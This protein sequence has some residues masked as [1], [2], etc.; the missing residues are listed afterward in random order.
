MVS[1][2]WTPSGCQ[3]KRLSSMELYV[4]IHQLRAY[5]AVAGQLELRWCKGSHAYPRLVALHVGCEIHAIVDGL[6]GWPIRRLQQWLAQKF[7]MLVI[8][9]CGAISNWGWSRAPLQYH[10]QS[11]YC[12]AR[13]PPSSSS[14][15]WWRSLNHSAYKM[16]EP[17]CGGASPF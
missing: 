12:K 14:Q 4:S 9:W 5:C 17:A 11:P 1:S 3:G 15:V 6:P 16:C 2:T 13:K 8:P 7:C 10:Y